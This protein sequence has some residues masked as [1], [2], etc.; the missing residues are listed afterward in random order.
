MI[1]KLP[2]KSDK[3]KYSLI[4][5]SI[6]SNLTNTCSASN[7]NPNPIKYVV[8]ARVVSNVQVLSKKYLAF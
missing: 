7:R 6:Y 2:M 8:T 1:C 5:F 3:L 4:N